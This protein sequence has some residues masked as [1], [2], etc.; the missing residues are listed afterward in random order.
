MEWHK[1]T[2]KRVTLT[3]LLYIQLFSYWSPCCHQLNT[4][5]LWAALC[6]KA[7]KRQRSTFF[8]FLPVYAAQPETTISERSTTKTPRRAAQEFPQNPKRGCK[9]SGLFPKK[10]ERKKKELR[11]LQC[12]VRSS[13]INIQG[14]GAT[15]FAF[16][17][18]VA[19]KNISRLTFLSVCIIL[20]IITTQA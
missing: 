17:R 14:G 6:P 1:N 16:I 3:V 13:W 18:G 8:P 11:K 12:C 20:V 15:C 4:A 19:V 5:E 10:E 9:A 7:P 2:N